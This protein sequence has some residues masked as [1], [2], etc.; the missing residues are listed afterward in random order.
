MSE[1][2]QVEDGSPE[3]HTDNN[4]YSL[5]CAVDH[6]SELPGSLRNSK[7]WR[8]TRACVLVDSSHTWLL[9]LIFS[10][11]SYVAPICA[12]VWIPCPFG[13]RLRHRTRLST[14]SLVSRQIPLSSVKTG[15][16]SP[17]ARVPRL[18]ASTWTLGLS[19]A[20]LGL[21]HAHM[22]GRSFSRLTKR[23][24]HWRSGLQLHFLGTQCSAEIKANVHHHSQPI[25]RA[26]RSTQIGHL[27][28]HVRLSDRI[29][30][31]AIIQ[32]DDARE[33]DATLVSYDPRTHYLTW[34]AQRKQKM[35]GWLMVNVSDQR[36]WEI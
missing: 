26:T 18:G 36:H 20:G 8:L 21:S 7:S 34:G 10:N 19:G 28:C 25:L 33:K 5:I 29:E 13:L 6:Y 22:T 30:T 24:E 4:P 2:P 1:R 9:H 17:A 35:C 11:N 27:F 16:S 12:D 3:S 31:Q 14:L 32:N 23:H 15:R